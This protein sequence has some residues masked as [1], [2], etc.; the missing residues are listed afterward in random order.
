MRSYIS[1]T[2]CD[3]YP[4]VFSAVEKALLGNKEI[5][6]LHEKVAFNLSKFNPIKWFS[7]RGL[8][9]Q[10]GKIK[11]MGQDFTKFHK[12]MTGEIA[13]HDVGFIKDFGQKFK[14]QIGKS[15]ALSKTAPVFEERAN[16]IEQIKSVKDP[17]ERQKHLNRLSEIESG[18]RETY[19][20]VGIEAAEEYMKLDPAYRKFISSGGQF[21]EDMLGKAEQAA[22]QGATAGGAEK[23]IGEAVGEVAGPQAT[24]A[25]QAWYNNPWV[26]GAIGAGAI[27]IPGTLLAANMIADKARKEGRRAALAAGGAGLATGIMAG[28]IIPT[29]G[30]KLMNLG[31]GLTQFNAPRPSPMMYPYYGY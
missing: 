3:K 4:E 6:Y 12:G 2:A 15:E 21:T 11:G 8:M 25:Q 24:A 14:G 19:G 17:L 30:E 5:S 23:T 31:A 1:K 9:K 16:L 27:G 22:A 10:V 20:D 29:V 28:R 26:A 18:L 13:P 7:G